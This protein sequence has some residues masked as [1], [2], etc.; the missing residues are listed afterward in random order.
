MKVFLTGATGTLGRPTARALIEAGHEVRGT[1]RGEEK[2]Q[3][4]RSLG[5]EPVS[6]NLFDAEA[7]KAAVAGSEAVFHFATKIPPLTRVRWKRAW[8]ENDRLRG[9][10]T[11]I[12]VDAAV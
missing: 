12:L 9:E 2:A 4:L 3:L 11:R 5:A 10:A 7:V 6:V 8:R 1:A